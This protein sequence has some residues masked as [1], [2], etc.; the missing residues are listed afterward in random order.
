MNLDSLFDSHAAT[1]M[2]LRQSTVA[3]RRA[4]LTRLLHEIEARNAAI[5][6]AAQRDLA[7]NPTETNLIEVLPLI[8]EIKHTLA[9]L[10]RWMKPHRIGATLATLGTRSRVVYQPKG[11]CLVISP[12][13]YPLS[14]SLGPLVSAVAAGN[15]VILKP[16][17]FTPHT[18]RVVAEI[19][20]AAFAQEEVAL[21]EGA[22]D[23]ASALL[24]RPFDHIFFTG[25]PAVG[26]KVM[27]AAA[28][29]LTSI[30]LELGGKSPAIVDAGANLRDA[31][32][33]IVWGKLVNA[34]Q[35][36][37]APDYLYVHRDVA[38]RFVELCRTLIG[39]R[40]GK[41]DAA[42]R[43]SPDFARMIHKRHAERAAWLIDNA[44]RSGAKLVCGGTVDLETRY[45]APTLLLD[46]PATAQI[47]HEEIFAPVLPI[48]TFDSLDSVI[49]EINLGPKPLAMYV[50]TKNDRTVQTLQT[51][52]SSGSLCVNLCMQQFA[53][54]N[55]PFGGV[56][57]S[58]MGNAHGFFGFKAFSHERATM[59]AG[60]W[61]A[62]KL[63]FPPYDARK[64]RLT[65]LLIKYLT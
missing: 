47:R 44:V 61:T 38:E 28:A 26:K 53:Q 56:G 23:V 5:L 39:E 22:A 45:I 6:E 64:R 60:P 49:G 20:A 58:G 3:E 8:G 10:K 29:N 52:T 9:H 27:A 30:T 55:L 18:N 12:W 24:A 50:W 17:E 33:H 43:S 41:D 65:D 63:L 11:R 54:H 16:S 7:R 36:C 51:R 32:Q 34:G 15:T 19:L 4:K 2:K 31:A 46:V 21:V 59:K 42:I 1:A 40:F 25:S 35:T 62:L 37:V 13:N 14:L 48:L 57:N